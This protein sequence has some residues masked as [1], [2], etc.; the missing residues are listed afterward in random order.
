MRNR[1]VASMAALL[2][3]AMAF[4]SVAHAQRGQR[5]TSAPAPPHDPRDLSG[6]WLLNDEDSDGMPGIPWTRETPPMTPE[7][8]AKFNANKPAKGPRAVH[9][10]FYN[11]PLGDANPPGLMRTL[12]YSRPIE[13]VQLQD[14]VLQLF[15]WAHFWRVIW[16][17]GKFPKIPAL[18]GTDI[19][20]A[21]GNGTHSSWRRPVWT[22]DNGS[23]TGAPRIATQCAC[24][25]VGGG[26]I[27][28]TW[29]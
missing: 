5:G 4:L 7:G 12:V 18:F 11:D 24:R 2:L 22:Q 16:T 23:T 10:A 29:S 26:W 27:A 17:D 3:A 13:F 15:E 8:L 21:N 25:N 14:K 19:Q 20:W 28:T 9:P 6:V 1:I